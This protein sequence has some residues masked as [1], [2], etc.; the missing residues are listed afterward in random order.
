MRTEGLL[1]L[2][3]LARREMD[4]DDAR[5]ELGGRDP[6]DSRVVWCTLGDGCRLVVSFAEAPGDPAAARARLEALASAFAGLTTEPR[7]DTD[8]PSLREPLQRRIDAELEALALRAEAL[9]AVVI[10]E[11]SPV[12]W[13]QSAARD[14]SEDVATLAETA[15]LSEEAAAQGLDLAALLAAVDVSMQLAKTSLR[16]ADAQRMAARIDR[17]RHY[18]DDRDERGWQ[19]YV[20]I[21]RAVTRVRAETAKPDFTSGH[22]RL[23][24]HADTLGVWARS[25]ATIYVLV[26]VYEEAFSE[27][28]AEGAA[29]HALPLIERLILALPPIDPSPGK[30]EVIR[31]RKR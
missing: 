7:R 5:V 18:A 25:F 20:L 26:M 11:K 23:A 1:R 3:E 30:A 31:F 15:A 4:A 29:L 14:S 13:G 21:A 12:V 17:V 22:L 6:S 27:L 8:P 2:V 10:D 28:H 24:L 16:A 9:A 19:V